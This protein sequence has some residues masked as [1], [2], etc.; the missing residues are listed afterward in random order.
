MKSR[1][2]VGACLAQDTATRCPAKSEVTKTPICAVSPE[3]WDGDHEP[4]QKQLPVSETKGSGS[5]AE[6]AE[7]TGKMRF[8]D[9][10]SRWLGSNVISGSK[11]VVSWDR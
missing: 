5:S 2:R 3:D 4:L 8:M 9:F 7:P 11:M 10:R 1:D 6:Y